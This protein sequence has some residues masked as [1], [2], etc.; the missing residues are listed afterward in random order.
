[1][2]PPMLPSSRIGSD[3]HHH[4]F[5]CTGKIYMRSVCVICSLPPPYVHLPTN[6]FYI[7]IWFKGIQGSAKV[8]F[9]K[10][11]LDDRILKLYD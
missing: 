8:T 9:V 4:R 5:S 3:W 6:G 1:M 10:G 2:S 7:P 11:V